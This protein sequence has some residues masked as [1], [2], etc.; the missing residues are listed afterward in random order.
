MSATS[1]STDSIEAWSQYWSA[2]C[3]S[4]CPGATDSNYSG[5]IAKAW[6]VFFATLPE[7]VR[8]LDIACGNGALLAMAHQYAV[9]AGQSWHLT[10]VDWA[11]LVQREALQHPAINL[12]SGVDMHALPFTSG[13]FTVVCSQYGIEYGHFPD[14]L[15]EALRVLTR[16]GRFQFLLHCADSAIARRAQ[17]Q[18]QQID[19]L[20]HDWAL[21]ELLQ[22]MLQTEHDAQRFPA[23]KGDFDRAAAKAFAYLKSS[24]PQQ[25]VSLIE[26]SLQQLGG[27]W[28]VRHQQR[29][30]DL[31]QASLDA[32][33]ALQS[34][35]Q[36]LLD[37]QA[38]MLDQQQAASWLAQAEQYADNV[39][40]N[41][42]DDV[43][44]ALG[45]C[46]QGS[47]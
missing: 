23:A 7:H 28:Q 3:L 13:S 36:R 29:R 35:R 44:H 17:L 19:L 45:W 27:I 18:L 47:K 41:R 10:G 12:C 9:A 26:Q 20:Q 30:T 2:G 11:T 43:G 6:Q 21:L 42:L 38:A 1:A 14:N 34:L 37:Q 22:N 40:L 4:S 15:C 39:Q 5:A 33:Q 32:G 46:L 8:I 31:I 24:P 25:D 16:K